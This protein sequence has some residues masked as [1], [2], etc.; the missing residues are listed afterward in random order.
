MTGLTKEKILGQFFSGDRIPELLTSLLHLE[1]VTTVI[2]PMCGLGDMFRPLLKY[3]LRLFGI[4]IDKTIATTTQNKFPNAEIAIGNA[5]N[6]DTILSVAIENGFDLVITNPP[7][8]RREL[9][10][11]IASNGFHDDLNT[12]RR[13]LLDVLD[14]LN[15]IPI[16]DKKEIET[17]LLSIS[18]L[19]DLSIP[20]WILCMML[21]RPGG[22][23]ALVVPTAWMKREYARPIIDLLYRLCSIDYVIVDANR[24]WFKDRAQV[25]TSLVVARRKCRGA[26]F[27]NKPVKYVYLFSSACSH[28]S[29]IGNLPQGVNF[30]ESVN[31]GESLANYFE[32]ENLAPESMIGNDEKKLPQRSKLSIFLDEKNAKP[33][34]FEDLKVNIGQGLRTGANKFFYLTQ[35]ENKCYSDLID[36]PIEYTP[37]FFYPVIKNQDALTNHYAVK[38][39]PRHRVLYIQNAILKEDM[40]QAMSFNSYSALPAS[41]GEYIRTASQ[42]KIKGKCIPELSAVKTNVT[43]SSFK[44]A[45][46]FWYM[47][48]SASERHY[49]NVFLPRVNSGA[50]VARINLTGKRIFLDANFINFWLQPSSS[51]TNYSLLALLNSTWLKIQFEEIGSV[52]GGG[53][54]KLD[55]VQIKKCFLPSGVLEKID[56]LNVL[57]KRLSQSSP[58]YSEIIIR[59]IDSV[60]LDALLIDDPNA[61]EILDSIL[62]SYLSCRN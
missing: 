49:A 31:K 4:E 25:Q 18:N 53:A 41:I 33:L 39:I 21:L 59:Q 47:L 5:F 40:P 50:P 35:T 28:D 14:K 58:E 1:S 9:I 46:R 20:S 15:Y 29:L 13:S 52:M 48:P 34:T 60:I 56:Q 57:G 6:M 16:E 38:V 17:C 27:I 37:D 42:I 32:V 43:R 30:I 22:Q 45:Q 2:D 11:P 44:R 62:N 10:N 61:L 54:L 12:I 23:L 51:L 19:A 26:V 3:D 36:N 24:V 55:A 7:Y 8:V